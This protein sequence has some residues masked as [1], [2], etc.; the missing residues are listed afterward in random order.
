MCD[1]GDHLKYVH[2]VRTC[3][4]TRRFFWFTPKTRVKRTEEKREREREIKMRKTT[5]MPELG[6]SFKE[7]AAS[8]DLQRVLENS[9]WD[10]E[11]SSSG[12]GGSTVSSTKS[13]ILSAGWFVLKTA[14]FTYFVSRTVDMISD[15]FESMDP[16]HS[17]KKNAKKMRSA[18]EKRLK[19][20]NRKLFETNM[21]E[22][23]IAQ[24]LVNPDNIPVTFDDIGGLESQKKD[25]YNLVVL[26]LKRPELFRG[27]GK[28]FRPPQ[29]ILL[30]GVPGTGKTML[31]KAIAKESGA[32]FI[33]LRL[34][35]LM[36]KYFGESQH[37]VRA[38]FSLARKLSPTIIFIDEI[39]GF[40][41]ARSMNDHHVNANIKAEFM[42]LWDVC[43]FL[44][45]C[46]LDTFIS[47]QRTNEQKQHRDS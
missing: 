4:K 17:E 19:E 24:D 45:F 16:M 28:L 8:R 37:L 39:D 33:N 30:Y 31:A 25:I 27:R 20:K 1:S 18:L 22:N 38:L 42:Q 12:Q 36:N 44:C 40:L 26:P 2:L 13:M 34:S 3:T 9:Y 11:P 43:I 21:Y 7:M 32:A 15:M 10:V 46:A 5:P 35:T 41:R 29:G 47:N 23:T 6:V 14:F